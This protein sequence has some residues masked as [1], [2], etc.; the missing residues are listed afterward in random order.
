MALYAYIA[1]GSLWHRCRSEMGLLLAATYSI[2][3]CAPFPPAPKLYLLPD[4]SEVSVSV[5]VITPTHPHFLPLQIL[6]QQLVS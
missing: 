4:H 3:P 1:A 5:E 2:S 6:S